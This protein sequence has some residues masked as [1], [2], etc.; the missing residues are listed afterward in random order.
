LSA[1]WRGE[2][3]AHARRNLELPVLVNDA[4]NRVRGSIRFDVR[5]LSLGG[6]FVRSDLLFEIGEEL[7]VEFQI[8]EG[9][10]VRAVARVVRVA[11]EPLDDAGMG[12]TFSRMDEDDKDAVR[13]FL[14]PG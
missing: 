10:L 8:P 14:S 7:E 13:A 2:R 11:R 5:D 12:I 1:T 6:A 9:P 3:R 4:G